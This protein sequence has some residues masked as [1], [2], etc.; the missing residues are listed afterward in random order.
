MPPLER[1]GILDRSQSNINSPYRLT[2]CRIDIP[3]T[4]PPLVATSRILHR[5]GTHM[6][7]LF[8]NI[9]ALQRIVHP[10]LVIHYHILLTPLR[11]SCYARASYLRLI[12]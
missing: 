11:L 12:D 1:A 9:F 8:R 10:I 4:R 7:P 3:V 5:K 6:I 2:R